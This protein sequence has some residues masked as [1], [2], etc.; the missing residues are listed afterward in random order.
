METDTRYRRMSGWMNGL[1]GV[2]IFSGSLPA[3]RVAVAVLD[4]LFVTCARAA[5][6]G[7]LASWFL[8]FN[9]KPWPSA[10][11]MSGLLI[12]AVCV[13][14]GF[15]LL[16]A[17]ALRH[18]TAAHATVFLGVLP[19]ST[20]LFAVLRGAE[21]P[22][23]LF[24]AFAALGSLVAVSFAVLH[25]PFEGSTVG[26]G[27]MFAACVMGGL[28][29]AEGA[30]LARHLGALQVISWALV[31][32]MPVTL[33]LAV[34]QIPADIATVGEPALLGLAHVSLF[35]MYIGFAFWYRGLAQGGIAAVGQLQLL[36]PFLSFAL[37][38]LFLGEAVTLAMLVASLA[39][40]SCVAGARRH[41]GALPTL[42]A[43]LPADSFPAP[44]AS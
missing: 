17:F 31:L 41:S 23:P 43:A 16:G 25:S 8:V 22:R 36:Q 27:L 5:A 44:R 29:Y 37:A 21:R 15:P 11:D 38:F 1:L 7:V 2:L 40:I 18:V 6:A 28:G 24:W 26:D 35:S 20:A 10:R 39:V 34:G 13:V 33:P 19:M 42:S 32:V 12:V 4:P 3:T 30:R 14:C 9:R